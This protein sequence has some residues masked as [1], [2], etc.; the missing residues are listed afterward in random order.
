M[1]KLQQFKQWVKQS[2]NPLAATI[3]KSFF[4]I[5]SIEVPAIS[6]FYTPLRVVYQLIRSSISSLT[7][8]LF[9]TPMFKT[10][11]RQVGKR[12][13]L[14]GGMPLVQGAL[15][16]EIGDDCRVSGQTTFSG[17]WAGDKT[18]QLII[19]SNVDISWQTTIAV[20]SKVVL[21]D[22]VRIAGK[23]FLAGYPGHPIDA[24]DRAKGLPELDSQVG[25]IILEDDVWLASGVMVMKGVTIGKGTIVA[26]GSVVTQNLPSGVIAAGVPAKVVRKIDPLKDKGAKASSH[27]H[28]VKA[29]KVTS[30]HKEVNNEC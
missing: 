18:P 24:E 20:G 5:K 19:G 25:D 22:N 30:I 2:N 28:S 1:N 16:I 27:L 7:R 8:I 12:L 4:A 15:Q 9:W 17:R 10:Q 14:F 23:G 21:G 13:Y 29:T 11:L 3:K 6:L 26:A